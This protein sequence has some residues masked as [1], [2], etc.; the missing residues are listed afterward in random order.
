[1]YA[2]KAT[3]PQRLAPRVPRPT[4]AREYVRW[5]G[6]RRALYRSAYVV[7]NRV[8]A[9][10]VLDCLELRLDDLSSTLVEAAEGYERGFLE[11][12]QA[13]AF[14]GTLE[15]AAAEIVCEAAARGD[16][17]YALLED[18]EPISVGCYSPRPTPVLND[19]I[20]HFEP[21][22]WYM[23]GGYTPP[24]HRGRRLHGIGVVSAALELFEQGVPALVTVCERTNYASLNSALRMGWK[25]CGTIHRVGIGPWT[26]LGRSADARGRRMRLERRV[27]GH[28]S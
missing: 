19:L 17:C 2:T 18:G 4:Q 25:P 15:P 11:P 21:P 6:L 20:V 5:L 7:A 13:T 26:R 3:Q 12:A 10:S 24:R 27:K 9:L 14:A 1:M 23:F 8:V 28:T 22:D 16:A